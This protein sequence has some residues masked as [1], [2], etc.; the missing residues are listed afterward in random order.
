MKRS[1]GFC[2]QPLGSG[3]G[4]LAR[5]GWNAQWRVPA[6]EFNWLDFGQGALSRT[7]QTKSAICS[8][9]RRLLGGI[10]SSS[11]DWR[12]A[13]IKRLFSGSPGIIA[14]PFWPPFSKLSRESSR[15]PL[16]TFSPPWHFRHELVR[17]GRILVSKNVS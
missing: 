13:L 9:V 16:L 2:D 3:G 7:H 12:I 1:I 8:S 10:L 6:D 14:R 11:P 5:T 4:S 17:T 15:S